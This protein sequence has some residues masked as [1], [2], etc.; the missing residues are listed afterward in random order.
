M[1]MVGEIRDRETA[2]IAVAGI[3]DRAPRAFDRPHQRRPAAITRMRDMGVEPFLSQP[4]LRAVSPSGWCGGCAQVPAAASARSIR[5]WPMCSGS[6]AGTTVGRSARL[7]RSAARADTPAGSGCS[8]R[9][10]VDEAVRRMIHDNAD[11]AAI[12]AHAFAKAPSLLQSAR[13]LV[14]AGGDHARGSRAR[15]TRASEAAVEA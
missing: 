11:E 12:A 10:A 1:I 7:R 14:L 3:A 8:R 6:G 5:G 9:C 2:E 15:V 13:D 4:A